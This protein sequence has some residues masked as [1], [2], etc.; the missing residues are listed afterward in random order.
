VV[1]QEFVL[2][3]TDLIPFDGPKVVNF[4]EAL[5]NALKPALPWLEVENIK[6]TVLTGGARC[7]VCGVEENG[8]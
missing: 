8:C 6:V 5:F 2:T 1:Q 4:K 7:V 3:G